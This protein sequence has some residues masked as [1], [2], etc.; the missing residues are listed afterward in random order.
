GRVGRSKVTMFRRE[1]GLWRRRHIEI[2]EY[3][4]SEKQIRGALSAAGFPQVIAL[5]ASRDLGMTNGAGR[6]FYLASRSRQPRLR[7]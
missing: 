4:F 3:C 1:N 5:D 2:H 7:R 6:M